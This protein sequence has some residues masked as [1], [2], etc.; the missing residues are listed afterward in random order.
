M[1]RF[2]ASISV[3][4]VALAINCPSLADEREVKS[5]GGA[6]LGKW[7]YDEVESSDALLEVALG[8][9]RLISVSAGYRA[10]SVYMERW[11]FND[12]TLSYEKLPS[13][14][15]YW[16]ADFNAKDAPRMICGEDVGQYCYDVKS[17]K[18]SKNLIIVTYKS[19]QTGA[20]CAT[21]IYVDEEIYSEGYQATYG[22]YSARSAAC[23]LPGNDTDEAVAL[24]A[25]YL[26]LAKKDGRPIAH[27][28]RYNLPE[29]KS[30]PEPPAPAGTTSNGA[31]EKRSG[32]ELAAVPVDPATKQ[33]IIQS[34][35][36]H[37]WSLKR[38]LARL[39]ERAHPELVFDPSRPGC[40]M[41]INSVEVLARRPDGF[42]LQ[43]E[44]NHYP[45]GSTSTTCAQNPVTA[46]DVFLFTWD[47]ET[48]EPKEHL[49]A[50]R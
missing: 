2:L 23:V 36:D 44:Y 47:G 10:N 24:S 33:Q 45:G 1:N 29:P 50:V 42:A 18:L 49:R 12:S 8:G 48:A 38:R 19:R 14:A 6:S 20:P 32:T 26:S 30:L 31:A 34:I 17:N 35:D 46:V 4:L 16:E 13:D 25:Y 28:K 21:L 11:R 40:Y 41:D 39:L 22:D 5:T 37:Q 3:L 7:K 43:I 27:L 15:H 9:R